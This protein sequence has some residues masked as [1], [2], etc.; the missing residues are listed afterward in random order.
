MRIDVLRYG[1]ERVY[2]ENISLRKRLWEAERE[3][4]ILSHIMFNF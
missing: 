3:N 4:R 2:E 1:F